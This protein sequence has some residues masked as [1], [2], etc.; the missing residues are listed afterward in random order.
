M[1]QSPNTP[2]QSDGSEYA[3]PHLL[4]E[5]DERVKERFLDELQR[6]QTEADKMPHFL[7]FWGEEKGITI[8]AIVLTLIA[9]LLSLFY[10]T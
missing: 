8:L 10:G 3:K 1:N 2:E 6:V 5:D 9:I 4:P 7:S